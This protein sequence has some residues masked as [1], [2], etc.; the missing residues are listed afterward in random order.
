MN[1]KDEE[2]ETSWDALKKGVKLKPGHR[3]VLIVEKKKPA[4]GT[5]G[6]RASSS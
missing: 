1:P 2:K 4:K 6:T 3:T 5:G